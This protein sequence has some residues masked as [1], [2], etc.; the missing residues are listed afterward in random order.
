MS[1]VED[2]EVVRASP[3]RARSLLTVRAAISSA[4]SV[5]TPFSLALSLMCSYWRA[6]FVPFFTPRGG[7]QAPFLA[8]FQLVPRSGR[9]KRRRYDGRGAERCPSWP[10]ERDWKSR[11]RRKLGRGF[12]S[13]P[14]RLYVGL[15]RIRCERSP[16]ASM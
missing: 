11:T 2:R 15:A 3:D 9:T 16:R 10:K 7:M 1:R 14:L 12:E 13:R 8:V 5:E 6:R 4:R